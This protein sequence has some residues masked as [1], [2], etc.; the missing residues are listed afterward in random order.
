MSDIIF[1][2]ERTPTGK[3]VTM[4][5]LVSNSVESTGAP[6]SG[7]QTDRSMVPQTPPWGKGPTKTPEGTYPEKKI[8]SIIAQLHMGRG[9]V[10]EAGGHKQRVSTALS[11]LSAPLF[12]SGGRG[13]RQTK[14]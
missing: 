10:G 13:E 12:S 7:V 6:G 9:T 4:S 14:A 8:V 2:Y 5:D 11:T 1:Q 3:S